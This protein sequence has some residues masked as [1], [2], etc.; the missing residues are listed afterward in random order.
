MAISVKQFWYLLGQSRL[1]TDQ[2]CRH[3]STEFQLTATDFDPANSQA[4]ANWLV[5]KNRLSSY[6]AKLLLSGRHG[7][8]VL[9]PYEIY[10]FIKTGFLAGRYKALHRPTAHPVLVQLVSSEQHEKDGMGHFLSRLTTIRGT[11]L[12][13][14]YEYREYEGRHLAIYEDVYGVPLTERLCWMNTESIAVNTVR[15][16][17]FGLAILHQQGI[18]HGDVRAEAVW[19]CGLS[20]RVQIHSPEIE[21]SITKSDRASEKRMREKR[22][23][24]APELLGGTSRPHTGSDMYALGCLF[25]RLVSV[26]PLITDDSQLPSDVV[27]DTIQ[28]MTSKDPTSRHP[29]MEVLAGKLDDLVGPKESQQAQDHATTSEYLRWLQETTP[30]SQHTDSLPVAQ[31]LSALP[32]RDE[33]VIGDEFEQR[34]KTRLTSSI[35]L[36]FDPGNLAGARRRDTSQAF[37]LRQRRS[38]I[39]RTYVVL[40]LLGLAALGGIAGLVKFTSQLSSS[41]RNQ[42]QPKV[43]VRSL[44]ASTQTG[45][46]NNPVAV[47]TLST[48]ASI[49]L[50]E[51]DGN[52]LWVSPTNGRPINLK[53]IPPGAQ[54]LLVLRPK[55]MLSA[56]DNNLLWRAVGPTVT[57]LKEQWEQDTAVALSE[58]AMLYLAAFPQDVGEPRVSITVQLRQ[59]VNLLKRWGPEAKQQSNLP[60]YK[61]RG[62][63][64]WFP[65]DSNQQW[66]VM[67]S[68]QEITSLFEGN[69]FVPSTDF[70]RLL[71]SSD[72]LRHLT[73]IART[74]F[75]YGDGQSLMRNDH[76]D[77]RDG[78]GWILG[79]GVTTAMLS[80]HFGETFFGELSFIDID[81]Q[82][83]HRTAERFRTQLNRL[84]E[85]IDRY[86]DTIFDSTY[87]RELKSRF[88]HMIRYLARQARIGS[89]NGIAMANFALPGSAAHNI[90]LG[91]EL[92]LATPGRDAATSEPTPVEK[93]TI[94]DVLDRPVEFRFDQH[95]LNNAVADLANA[96]RETYA[97]LAYFQIK[98]LGGDLQNEGISRNQQIRDFQHHAPLSQVL[99][100]LLL[101][102]NPVPN[103]SGPSDPQQK[104]VWTFGSQSADSTVLITTRKAAKERN[105]TLPPEFA[106]NSQ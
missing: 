40:V 92:S 26:K 50:V 64:F 74:N 96:V 34:S 36:P 55:D 76:L 81:A 100:Q 32:E 78:L 23:Y 42:A 1:A 46:T 41:G 59:P 104:I 6:Q 89:E 71:Q 5:S 77:L 39:R 58:V 67:A 35:S 80:F 45:T 43:H 82:T 79:N 28:K 3:W 2:Q 95:S 49:E 65:L 21:S 88:P 56:K 94:R 83:P 60:V 54:A 27:A 12:S 86:F 63:S 98:I 11:H 85:K 97:D 103:I 16:I 31:V 33:S 22:A 4:L 84:S 14:I 38:D 9:G 57:R 101:R 25:R 106:P 51:D 99:T 69:P 17:A 13:N 44:P 87:W 61:M 72:E 19:T 53:Y 91:T 18:V 24:L 90:V 105:L 15:D 48:S 75:L 20:S 102:A 62:W 8:L 10:E 73:V 68:Q 52:H 70:A 7:P 37:L 29:N 93:L 30:E 66:F 47:E